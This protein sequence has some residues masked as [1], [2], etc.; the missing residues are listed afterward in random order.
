M[1]GLDK[2]QFICTFLRVHIASYGATDFPID[3]FIAIW[4]KSALMTG[5]YQA[6]S[7]QFL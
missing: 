5:V 7:E 2:V 6:R 3:V 1:N 4:R